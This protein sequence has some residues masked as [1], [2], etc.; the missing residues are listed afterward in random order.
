MVLASLGQENG[1]NCRVAQWREY[2]S[3]R[4][5]RSFGDLSL[6]STPIDRWRTQNAFDEGL[7]V[8]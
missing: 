1:T 7:N 8:A 6:S 2:F 3:L 4:T 5:R